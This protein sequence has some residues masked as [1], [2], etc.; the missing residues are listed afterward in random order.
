MPAPQLP[1]FRHHPSAYRNLRRARG[2]DIPFACPSPGRDRIHS[3]R[4]AAGSAEEVRASLLIA[5]A[6][7]YVEPDILAPSLE[8]LDRISAMLYRMTH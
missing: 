5:E 3:W 8:L 2:C 7:G 6:W 4:I 1:R